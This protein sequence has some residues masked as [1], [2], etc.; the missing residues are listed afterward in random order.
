V[1]PIQDLKKYEI[2]EE[3]DPTEL[4]LLSKMAA[5]AHAREGEM[6]IQAGLPARMLYILQEGGLMVGALWLDTRM[7]EPSP[8]IRRV[9]WWAGRRWLVPLAPRHR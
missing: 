8:S 7:V 9:A 5:A 2:F 1:I 4:G 6:L 3:L